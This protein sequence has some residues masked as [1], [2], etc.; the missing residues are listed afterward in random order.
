MEPQSR[1]V[2]QSGNSTTFNT[3]TGGKVEWIKILYAA[4]GDGKDGGPD[5]LLEDGLL[6]VVLDHILL[7]VVG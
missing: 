7:K 3:I 5:Q 4:L 2:E 6:A 1:P